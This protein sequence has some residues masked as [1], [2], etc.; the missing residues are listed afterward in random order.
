MRVGF[1]GLGEMG[2]GMAANL[3]A[4]GHEVTVWNRSPGPAQ[5]LGSKGARV[6]S[7]PADTV[8]GEIVISMLADDAAVL[9]IFDD[10]LLSRAAPGLLHANM[11]TVSIEAVR[12]LA[13]RHARHRIGY[14]AAPVFG[15]GDAAAAAKLNIIAGG[16]DAELARLRP[17]FDVMG[18]KT[19]PVGTDP[20][21]A[22]TVKIAGNL[23]IATA[24]ELIGE[25]TA[26]CAKSGVDPKA[27]TEIMTNT[28]FACPVFKGYSALI[29]DKNYEPAGFRLRLGLKDVTLALG[30][31][32]ATETPLPLASL[33]R[34]QFLEAV[35]R[36]DG[37]K[38]WS[39]IAAVAARKAGLT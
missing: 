25:T 9:S 39:A 30:A 11:A 26:L 18:Q 29:T 12:T 1:L 6:A 15:R 13:E 3:I 19:W 10:A 31:G 7:S 28:I 36:G 37:D 17:L 4:A 2:R 5:A 23:M 35:A 32:S 14:F 33:L 34:D 38:D 16:K 27:F 8:G 24:I 20:V 21:H 22:N